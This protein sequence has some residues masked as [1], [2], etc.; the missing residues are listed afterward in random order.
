MSPCR[1]DYIFTNEQVGVWHVVSED[2]DHFSA[3]LAVIHRLHDLHDLEQPARRDMRGRLDDLHA[4]YELL[5]IQ[6]FRRS[7]RVSLKE[8][9]DLF[10]KIAPPADDE[11]IQIFF[12]VVVSTIAVQTS[13]SEVLLHH[14]ETFGAL[15]A[16]C[17]HKLMR[18]LETG[19]V[20]SAGC[21]MR[22]PPEMD[23]KTPLSVDEASN[24]ADQSFLLIVRIRRIVTAR[25]A[26]TTRCQL[27]ERVPRHTRIFQHIARFY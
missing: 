1:S 6:A 14:C 11:L 8:R 21:A 13:N 5:E 7:Q 25:L 24:P 20:A 10:K 23:R 26:N 16:L 9:N 22:L 4:P 27:I 2:S 3:W 12:V 19:L 15:R 18:H 17:H